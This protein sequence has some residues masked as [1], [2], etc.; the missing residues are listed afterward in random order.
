[1]NERMAAEPT[2]CLSATE[3]RYLLTSFGPFA[4]R[5]LVAY[6]T[7]WR[8]LLLEHFAESPTLEQERV[9]ALLR[10][11]K[12]EVRIVGSGALPYDT[13]QAWAEN[14][15]AAI[16]TSPPKLHGAVFARPAPSEA[17][18]AFSM[19]SLDLPPTAD[20]KIDAVPSEFARVCRVLIAASREAILVDPYLNPCRADCMSVLVELAKQA[21]SAN[22]MRISLWARHSLVVGSRANDLEE[23]QGALAD[24]RTRSGLKRERVLEMHLVEDDRARDR[25]H[26]R[27]LLS[28]KGGV[29]LDQGFQRL[30]GGRK[31]DVSPVGAAL[32]DELL[33]VYAQGQHDMRVEATL[34][35]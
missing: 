26:G 22:C 11:A 32:L 9:K 28:V 4:G 12:E 2:S 5:Y 25:M 8:Q 1:M 19:D 17:P 15:M 27:Y 29:R 23:V 14:A 7:D 10:R 3:L 34:R 30:T 16:S 13:A 35:A 31:V 18:P 21:A 33:T 6:P 20:E 24:L